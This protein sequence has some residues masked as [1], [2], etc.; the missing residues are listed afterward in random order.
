[1]AGL[2]HKSS[3]GPGR[4]LASDAFPFSLAFQGQVWDGL[5]SLFSTAWVLC[6]G[7]GG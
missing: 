2:A 7:A 4:S 3:Q 1:M 5:P 6:L